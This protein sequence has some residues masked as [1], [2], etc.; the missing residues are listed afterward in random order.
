MWLVWHAIAGNYTKGYS[1]SYRTLKD[2]QIRENMGLLLNEVGALIKRNAEKME[3]LT[4]FFAAVLM[5]KLALM[6]HRPQK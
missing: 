1:F 5:L 3:I 2:S 6:N 4:A